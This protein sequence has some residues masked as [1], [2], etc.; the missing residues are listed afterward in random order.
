[1]TS[2]QLSG[3]PD[4]GVEG[5]GRRQIALERRKDPDRQLRR[6]TASKKLDECVQVIAPVIRRAGRQRGRN[7]RSNELVA[8]PHEDAVGAAAS[9]RLRP[10]DLSV[11]AGPHCLPDLNGGEGR[12]RLYGRL[13]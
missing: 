7:A 12:G 4:A 8:S 2:S 13:C 3:G 9:G 1:M 5:G 6:A 11:A 10:H